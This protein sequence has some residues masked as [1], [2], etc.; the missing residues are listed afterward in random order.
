MGTMFMFF[1][2]PPKIVFF[3]T[4]QPILWIA[5]LQ[6]WIPAFAGMTEEGDR[7]TVT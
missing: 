1:A 7:E 2:K 5:I 3:V 6:H 4:V